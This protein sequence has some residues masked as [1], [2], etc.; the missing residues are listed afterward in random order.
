[1][2]FLWDRH[3]NGARPIVDFD[4]DHVSFRPFFIDLLLFPAKDDLPSA[5]Y[6]FIAL[7]YLIYFA[8]LCLSR[9]F[10][11]KIFPHEHV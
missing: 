2:M 8:N 5:T 4:A 6:Y 11:L 9:L 3:H 1:M 7:L 10:R